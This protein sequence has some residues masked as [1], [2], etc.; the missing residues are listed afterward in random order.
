ML[1]GFHF[2]LNQCV[3][4]HACVV[5]CQI[6]NGSEQQV[7]WRAIS[8]YN[9]HQH[10]EL[11]LFHYSL[12]CNHCEDAPCKSSCPALA[13]TKDESL[14]TIVHH[15]ERCIGCTYCTWACPYDAPKFVHS[16][17]VVEKCTACQHRLE[18]GKKPACANLCP[19]GA[20]DYGTVSGKG[21]RRLPGFTEIG[22]GP[23]IEIVR[24]RRKNPPRSVMKLDD[25][26]KKEFYRLE[27]KLE[28]KIGLKKE[29]VL[30]LFTLLV[31]TL[32]AVLA[33]AVEGHFGFH[34]VPFMIA[35]IAGLMLSS[36]HLGKK[37]RAWRSVLNIR[38]SWLS[39][40]ILAYG[41][42]LGTAF[43]WILLPEFY[44]VGMLSVFIGIFTCYSMDKVY[45]HLEQT[46][47]IP[48]QSNNVFLTAL[49]LIPLLSGNELFAGIILMLK[50]VL[51]AYR[52]LYFYL[53]RRKT[54]HLVTVARIVLGFIIPPVLWL[55]R[56][57]DVFL[58]FYFILAGEVIDRIE[59]Y[60]EGE[61]MDPRRQI[62]EDL[63]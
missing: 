34:P 54:N 15:A 61:V 59:F 44:W 36:V 26:Q 27:K 24:L 62:V 30:V 1:Q 40:E 17:G 52:K 18:E 57:A 4:C 43:I 14:N 29:W 5:A 16:T 28:S 58:L 13:F 56:D 9:G 32:I 50:F 48:I 55:N 8:T 31:P 20:L 25:V 35:G 63:P 6:E 22:I 21:Q 19:T 12:A 39:R 51:Y 23:G 46:T 60:L 3:G 2:N 7:P 42:F 49:L 10:P 38:E 41:L 33:A 45:N 47:K 11:P 37:F 53:H